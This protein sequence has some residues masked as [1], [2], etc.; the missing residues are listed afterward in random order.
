MQLGKS[1]KQ[2]IILPSCWISCH[3]HM[4]VINNNLLFDI[5]YQSIKSTVE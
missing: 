4:N 1:F 5:I 2:S 3:C